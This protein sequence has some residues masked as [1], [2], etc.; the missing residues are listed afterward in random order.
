MSIVLDTPEQINM[1]V[2]LSRRHQIQLHLK[3]MTV[4]GLAASLKRT[5]PDVGSRYVKDYV[6]P[7]EFAISERGGQ[8]DYNLVN[9]HVMLKRGGMFHDRGVYNDPDAALN[10]H[11][12]FGPAFAKGQLEVVLTTDEPRPMT[13]EIF[14]PA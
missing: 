10:T 11:P 8:V 14:V 12:E 9:V 2:L 5:F 1:W 3:G 6:I 7:V 13:N 4:K